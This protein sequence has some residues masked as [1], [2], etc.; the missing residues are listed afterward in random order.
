[1]LPLYNCVGVDPFMHCKEIKWVTD[2][3]IKEEKKIEIKSHC[4]TP[5][6]T[7]YRHYLEHPEKG[8]FNTVNAINSADDLDMLEYALDCALSCDDYGCYTELGKSYS[9]KVGDDGALGAQ[10]CM[11]PYEMLGY[12]SSVTTAMLPYEDEP[13]FFRLMDKILELDKKIIDALAPSGVD[14]VFLGGPGSEMISPAYYE[15]YLV[16]YSKLVTD[17][18]HSKGLLIYSHICSPIEPMLSKG[19]Y[20]QMGIDLFE[21]LSPAPEGNIKSIADAFTKLDDKICTRGNVSLSK[22]VTGTP[23]LIRQEVYS[24]MEAAK[25]RKHIVAASDYLLYDVPEANVKALC[26]AV[27]EYYGL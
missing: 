5:H 10:W 27:E 21:T 23:E 9:Q 8:G 7:M 18:A 20:N 14:F 1:M 13:R 15:K 12:P 3:H 4:E 11:Q 19:Y 26:D 24:I 6:G 25:G 17:Y 16:P 22:L 2:S